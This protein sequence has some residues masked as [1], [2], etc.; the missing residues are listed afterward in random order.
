MD[1]AD[2]PGLV[3]T[4]SWQM[5]ALIIAVLLVTRTL[6]SNRVHLSYVLWLVVLLKCVT[7]PIWSSPTGIF[8]WAEHAFASSTVAENEEGLP[9]QNAPTARATT[10][11][12]PDSKRLPTLM[13]NSTRVEDPEAF[14][15]SSHPSAKINEPR[16]TL[17]FTF[18]TT[19]ALAC[20]WVLTSF[21]IVLW[22]CF[23]TVWCMRQIHLAGVYDDPRLTQKVTDLCCRLGVKRKIRCQVTRGRIGPAVFG[24]IRPTILIPEIILRERSIDEL[25]PILT[26][27]TLHV[28][29]GDLWV[30]VVQVM[31]KA[32]WWFNPFVWIAT[33]HTSAVAEACCDEQSIGSLKCDPHEYAKCLLHVLELKNSLKPMPAFPGV[34]PVE[35]TSKRLEKIMKLGQGCHMTT[36]I[37]CW[38]VFALAAVLAI[39]GAAIVFGED[40]APRP[41]IKSTTTE[42]TKLVPSVVQSPDQEFVFP[43]DPDAPQITINTRF[44]TV[45]TKLKE[46]KLDWSLLNSQ[47]SEK[48]SAK[49][50]GDMTKNVQDRKPTGR[51]RI[52]TEKN[53][54]VRFTILNPKEAESFID[55]AQ[56]FTK[57]NVLQAPKV[58]AFDSQTI[59]IADV[60]Q[61][62]FVTGFEEG[63]P[64]VKVL[65]D[66]VEIQCRGQVVEENAVWLQLE[67]THSNVG[68]VGEFTIRNPKTNKNLT[69]QSPEVSKT[70]IG[71]EL[72]VPSNQTLVL[73]GATRGTPTGP[74]YLLVLI[75]PQII[76]PSHDTKVSLQQPVISNEDTTGTPWDMSLDECIETSLHNS[77]VIRSLGQVRRSSSTKDSGFII[78]PND[79]GMLLVD[80]EA[81]VRDHLAE[82]ATSYWDLEFYYRNLEIAKD[83]RDSALTTWRRLQDAW[84][85]DDASSAQAKEQYF[86]FRGRTEEAQRDLIKAE[87]R[88]RYLCGLGARDGR[89]IR[90]TDE[91][92]MNEVLFDWEKSL[93]QTLNGAVEMKRQKTR[94]QQLQ[95]SLDMAKESLLPKIDH[96][97]LYRWLGLGDQVA[98]KEAERVVDD[99]ETME[100]RA[101]V[102]LETPI[103]SRE[104]LRKVRNI[105]LLHAREKAKLKDLELEVS[106]LLAESV[107]NV[108][109]NYT[110]VNTSEMQKNAAV[111]QVKELENQR[112][113]RKITLDFLLD[114]Q[115]RQADSTV[116]YY[117]SLIQY[118]LSIIKVHY[119]KG[120]LLEEFGVKIVEA[121]S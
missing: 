79:K 75:T 48:Q 47:D 78:I 60:S 74:Q 91:P 65:S 20:L 94:V 43:A 41:W 100:W 63:E 37:W 21:T 83:G 7:P 54:P 44:I 1:V 45:P 57:V 42:K 114:A 13:A 118:A 99:K 105:Q 62:P 85:A 110:L 112:K 50:A 11:W 61:R 68:D 67:L 5:V 70:I 8:S 3:A 97:N 81:T 18:S 58:T 19:R 36:P 46:F 10:P 119:Q 15:E 115:R 98:G 2:L 35:I 86:F 87:K 59:S 69:V 111:D 23:R 38:Y 30:N 95:E 113:A 51:S 89:I 33:R 107:Q 53:E 72:E 52:V 24:L 76:R 96:K 106:H 25:E 56:G 102:D 31:A 73:R 16:P 9:F 28:R 34:K 39:P 14:V 120:T 101:G 17:K 40:Q 27:E 92:P 49:A 71:I 80:L 121:R 29:R 64:K 12:K 22:Y 116:A 90:P 108:D 6:T 109:A 4:Q 82:L 93:K 104:E 77:K 88:L 26:H 32:L 117:Q 103:G 55:K 84:H 66:G